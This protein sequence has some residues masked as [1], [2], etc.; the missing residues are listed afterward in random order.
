MVNRDR[1][2]LLHGPY[3]HP[4]L[5]NGDRAFCLY[6]D[7]DVVITTWTNGRIVWPR[8]RSLESNGCGSGLLVNQTLAR[9]VRT[10][11]AAAI[12][13][14]WGV[15]D[16]AIWKWRMALGVTRK[17][18]RGTVRL[19]TAASKKGARVQRGVPLPPEAVEQRRRRALKLN[20]GR[21]LNLGYHGPRWTPK[22]LALLGTM[23]DDEVAKRVRRTSNAVRVMRGRLGIAPFGDR[24]W[25]SEQ[26]ALLGMA[27]D[28]EIASRI[29]RTPIAVTVKRYKRK[30]YRTDRARIMSPS[31]PIAKVKFTDGAVRPVFEEGGRQ[32][33]LDEDGLRVYGTWFLLPECDEPL[34]VVPNE[35]R[36]GKL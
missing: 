22:Q 7:C 21:N 18:N 17:N 13:H 33:V 28:K 11:S 25:T 19:M 30:I 31:I 35:P 29:G 6:R 36:R 8:C 3:P 24:H 1:I 5:R 10:E 14:W 16:K 2:K 27:S 4:P 26:L 12:K 9:A 20:L 32:Y 15:S 23:P 34:I